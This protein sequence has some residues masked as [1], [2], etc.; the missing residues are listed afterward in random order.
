M[1]YQVKLQTEIE[2]ARAEQRTKSE[3]EKIKRAHKEVKLK[4]SEQCAKWIKN[5]ENEIRE[6]VMKNPGEYR[7]DERANVFVY[8]KCKHTMLEMHTSKEAPFVKKNQYAVCIDGFIALKAR[9][10]VAQANVES[11]KKLGTP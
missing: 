3:E 5:A 6:T 9:Q 4:H 7:F 11:E 1:V 10:A 2:V 8:L